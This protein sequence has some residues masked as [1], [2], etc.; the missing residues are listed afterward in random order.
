MK[1]LITFYIA[2]GL[3][4]SSIITIE[5]KCK[6][7]ELFP[8][9]YGSPFVFAES[10]LASSME[11]YYGILPLLL[12]TLIWSLVLLIINFI[13]QKAVFSFKHFKSI[14][15]IQNVILLIL[16]LFST[17]SIIF[18]FETAGRG[19]K[20]GLNYWTLDMEKDAKIWK[21]ECKGELKIFKE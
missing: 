17:L 7:D 20:L 11:F 9:Y 3:V 8:K 1:Y 4:L 13:Y 15:N 2:L 21:M 14:K 19:F 6:G 10:S 5:Y 12:N 18:S 16:I